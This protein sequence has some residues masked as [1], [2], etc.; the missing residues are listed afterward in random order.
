MRINT[1]GSELVFETESIENIPAG[2]RARTTYRLDGPDTLRTFFELAEPGA[3]F[4]LYSEN[5]L[6]R[7]NG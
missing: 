7:K 4:T 1:D 3:E 5:C 2:F 6:Q